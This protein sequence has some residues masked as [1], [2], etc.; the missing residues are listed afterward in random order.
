MRRSYKQKGNPYAGAEYLIK[1][2]SVTEAARLFNVDRRTIQYHIDKRN[3][4]ARK[5]HNTY[6]ISIDSLIS[7]Y[8]RVPQVYS[9]LEEIS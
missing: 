8:G 2:V 4:A 3:I 6:I 7:Y 9:F 5:M 1:V